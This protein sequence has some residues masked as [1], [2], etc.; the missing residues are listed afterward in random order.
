LLPSIAAPEGSSILEANVEGGTIEADS[1]DILNT[2]LPIQDL[3]A[4]YDRELKKVRGVRVLK[5]TQIERGARTEWVLKDEECGDEWNG[6]LTV[7][8][9]TDPR[10]TVRI[11]RR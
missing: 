7:E 3:I 6:S 4:Y 1:V 11:A 8:G 2:P 9:G 10:V 5:R